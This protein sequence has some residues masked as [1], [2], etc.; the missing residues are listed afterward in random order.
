MMGLVP[1]LNI[2]CNTFSLQWRVYINILELVW[3]G[4]MLVAW[5]VSSLVNSYEWQQ[6]DMVDP[7]L[8]GESHYSVVR[9][10]YVVLIVTSYANSITWVCVHF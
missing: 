8:A 6:L 1:L 5:L 2:Y 10:S 4:L 7:A 9:E 3:S